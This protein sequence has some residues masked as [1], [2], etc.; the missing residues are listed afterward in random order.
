MVNIRLILLGVLFFGG[1]ALTFAGDLLDYVPRRSAQVMKID[2]S[3]LNEMKSFRN[4][5]LREVV[6][7]SGVED[8]KRDGETVLSMVKECLIVTP[9]LTEDYTLVF[10]KTKMTEDG[11]C[12]KLAELTGVR[13][14]PVKTGN[15]TENRITLAKTRSFPGS[16]LKARTFA[17][18]FLEKDIV[19]FAKNTLSGYWNYRT[20]GLLKPERASL[21]VPQALIAGFLEMSSGFLTENPMLPPFHRVVYSLVP[22][23]AGS[24]RISAAA[25]CPGEE[26]ARQV[27]I[28]IQQYVMVGGIFLNQTSPELMQ[29]WMNSVKVR[30]EGSRV[31]LTADFS[32]RFLDLLAETSEKVAG[33]VNSSPE[34]NGRK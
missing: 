8:G 3:V 7:Q 14:I 21:K 19:V 9:V 20:Y 6:R 22:G 18:A 34:P 1:S 27:Q 26:A 13:H 12:K 28:Q 30:G 25:E 32:K 23:S 10:I 24:L 16:S 11:F 15:R 4:D 2:F 17:F 29:E 33:N 31:L 5:V